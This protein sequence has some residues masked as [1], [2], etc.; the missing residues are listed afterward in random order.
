MKHSV[1]SINSVD[2]KN[3]CISR[4]PSTKSER[5]S[6]LRPP[7]DFADVV[8]REWCEEVGQQPSYSRSESSPLGRRGWERK[9]TVF[10]PKRKSQRLFRR[11]RGRIFKE[12]EMREEKRNA[13]FLP[14]PWTAFGG[15]GSLWRHKDPQ[16]PAL[17]GTEKPILQTLTRFIRPIFYSRV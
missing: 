12:G 10:F 4:R 15:L 2:L 14:P 6:V 13:S 8:Q 16:A 7:S 5:V 3:R 9:P 11:K 1:L 17:K